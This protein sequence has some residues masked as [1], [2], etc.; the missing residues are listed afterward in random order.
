VETPPFVTH[1]IFESQ[2]GSLFLDLAPELHQEGISYIS[3][4]MHLIK[5]R[6]K[7]V[8]V[9]KGANAQEVPWYLRS[10]PVRAEA[11]SFLAF[12]SFS[13]ANGQEVDPNSGG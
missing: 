2:G 12:P 10:K 11:E 1:N 6:E 7:N 4:R 3:E 5:N 13:F 8:C 9:W